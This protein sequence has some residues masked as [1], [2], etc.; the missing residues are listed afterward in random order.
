MSRWLLGGAF[1]V[2]VA[3]L[4]EVLAR[5]GILSEDGFSRPTRFLAAAWKA[6]GD[7]TLLQQTSETFGA[8][9]FGLCIAAVAGIAA[10]TLLGVSRPLARA[11]TLIIDALRTVPSVA[12]IPLSLLVFGFSRNMSAAVAAFACFWPILIVTASAVR[13]IDPRLIEVGRMLG[14]SLPQRILK[15]A[16]PAAIP[17]IMVGVRVAAGISIVV[18]VTTEIVSNPRGLGYGMSMAAQ[19]LQPDLAWATLLWIGVVGWI[20][21]WAILRLEQRWLPW[22]WAGRE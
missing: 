18:T 16:L 21:N 11:A 20:V 19:S 17:A 1:P 8:A 6:L 7:G 14:L 13:G 9:A 12:L 5:A 2:F 4:W 15:L 3:G 10:G 22:Y